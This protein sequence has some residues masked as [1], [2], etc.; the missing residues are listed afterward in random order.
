MDGFGPQQGWE[1]S[2]ERI[3]TS[4]EDPTKILAQLPTS[5]CAI[6]CGDPVV[7]EQKVTVW[8]YVGFVYVLSYHTFVLA[9]FSNTENLTSWLYIFCP[10]IFS[11]VTSV[12]IDELFFFLSLGNP[13]IY[14]SPFVLHRLYP[15]PLRVPRYVPLWPIAL[16]SDGPPN[17]SDI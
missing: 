17:C 1:D 16:S 8:K 4:I 2:L 15:P 3:K 9:M 14:W 12:R 6:A 5:S 10:A 11:F 13:M 7:G